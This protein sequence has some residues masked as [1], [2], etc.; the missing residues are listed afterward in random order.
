MYSRKRVS[1]AVV[2]RSEAATQN[3]NKNKSDY[4]L[5]LFGFYLLCVYYKVYLIAVST[6]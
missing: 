5:L 1:L 3:R 2:P 6:S 4:V